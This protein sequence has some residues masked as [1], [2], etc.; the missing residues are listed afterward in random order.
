V[1]SHLA[2]PDLFDFAALET[3]VAP[4]PNA[5]NTEARGVLT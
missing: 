4:E 2:D 1:P 3:L 5:G